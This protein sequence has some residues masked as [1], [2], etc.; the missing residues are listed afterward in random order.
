MPSQS[1]PPGEQGSVLGATLRFKGE[2]HADEDLMIR[3]QVQGK[4]THSQRLTIC[5]EAQ[6]QADIKG[7]VVAVEGTLVGDVSAATSVAVLESA[8]LT[9]DLTAPSITIVDG[10][11]FNGNVLMEAGK[12]GHSNRQSDA[13]P[14]QSADS[15]RGTNG[16]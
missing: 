10:A 13:R 15:T 2:L 16:R 12:K 7:E 3:G 1:D 5:R 14:A 4:I 6:V 8:R 11:N 9:G